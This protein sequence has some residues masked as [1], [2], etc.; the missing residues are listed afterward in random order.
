MSRI[1]LYTTEPCARCGNAKA[2][3]SK[4]GADWEEINLS[5]DPVGRAELAERTGLM[6]FPQ[7]V[8]DGEAVGGFDEL[9]VLEEQGGLADLLAA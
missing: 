5:K 6:T 1:V 4:H 9:R 2:L 3:L 8:V 7:V